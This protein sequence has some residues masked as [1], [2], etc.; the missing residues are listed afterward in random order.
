MYACMHVCMCVCM[1][2][3][4]HVWVY[5]CTYVH[6]CMCVIMYVSTCISE[7]YMYI[8]AKVIICFTTFPFN[9]V[10]TC[11]P[12]VHSPSLTN[13]HVTRALTHENTGLANRAS[14]SDIRCTQSTYF[15][16]PRRAQHTR[17]PRVSVKIPPWFHF[18]R[19]HDTAR[20]LSKVRL[21]HDSSRCG[22]D[23]RLKLRLWLTSLYV[24]Q[25]LGD[26]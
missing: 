5:V 14:S 8:W 23:P 9:F 24:H 10:N 22:F 15:L 13:I 18:L 21:Q 17:S 4:L 11:K 3:C 26:A 2:A 1:Y 16:H 7:W 12:C 6:L 19:R 20:C 25:N